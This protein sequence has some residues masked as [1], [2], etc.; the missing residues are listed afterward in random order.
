M[1]I[2]ERAVRHLLPDLKRAEKRTG[3]IDLADR[4]V[5]EF[6]SLVRF[7]ASHNADGG[8]KRIRQLLEENNAVVAV[9]DKRMWPVLRLLHNRPFYDGRVFL[10][11]VINGRKLIE[12]SI[13]QRNRAMSDLIDQFS[14]FKSGMKKGDSLSTFAV[15]K[16]YWAGPAHHALRDN[17]INPKNAEVRLYG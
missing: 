4:S 12:S 3:L 8:A 9:V 2:L 14:R 15:G 17:R 10:T 6:K 16:Q 1:A 13:E 11:V 5:P 7:N